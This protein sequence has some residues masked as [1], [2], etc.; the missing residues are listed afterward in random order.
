[1]DDYQQDPAHLTKE[2]KAGFVLLL[3]FGLLAV[4][5][6]FLQMRH[7]IYIP[8]LQ[9]QVALNQQRQPQITVE[10]EVARLQRIDT[11]QDGLN[12]YEELEFYQTSPYLPDTDSDGITDKAELERGTNPLCPEGQQCDA[13]ATAA[14]EVSTST[15]VESPLA[16]SSESPIALFEGAVQASGVGQDA[17]DAIDFELIASDPEALRTL[18]VS[19]GQVTQEQVD[20]FDDETLLQ[21]AAQ[22]FKFSQEQTQ[23][24]EDNDSSA[25]DADSIE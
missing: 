1:M 21:V 6:G 15:L 10:D 2:Q 22:A 7:N 17:V 18:L 14:P 13:I 3:F 20:A 11:D 25:S 12:D 4:G 8:F 23:G 24:Q 16:N 9:Q 5:L 19:S